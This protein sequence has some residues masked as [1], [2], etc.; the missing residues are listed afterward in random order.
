M[1][2]QPSANWPG[3][4]H[5]ERA[6]ASGIWHGK[7]LFAFLCS[8]GLRFLNWS[9]D[10]ALFCPVREFFDCLIIEQTKCHMKLVLVSK[11]WLKLNHNKTYD[12]NQVLNISK[13]V[14]LWRYCGCRTEHNTWRICRWTSGPTVSNL[15]LFCVAL[16]SL[17]QFL[18]LHR[19]NLV[20]T[21][22]YT[23]YVQL[24]FHVDACGL[25]GIYLIFLCFFFRMGLPFNPLTS[26]NP[27]QTMGSDGGMLP[28]N[29]SPAFPH[30]MESTFKQGRR[31]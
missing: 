4:Q 12:E 20:L 26:V 2:F 5:S 25:L 14:M 10:Y 18:Y 3:W 22:L 31:F 30:R 28:H 15:L 13:V 17:Y 11:K 7:F 21:R 24:F 9:L 16:F 8:M 29:I 6:D 19:S 1:N 23:D 27:A